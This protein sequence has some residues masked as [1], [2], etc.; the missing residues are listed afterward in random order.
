M[1]LCVPVKQD[2]RKLKSSLNAGATFH[3]QDFRLD[4]LAGFE[5]EGPLMLIP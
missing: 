4:F 3:G 5:V 2:R 1:V